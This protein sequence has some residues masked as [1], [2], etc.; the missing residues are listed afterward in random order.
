MSTKRIGYLPILFLLNLFYPY[1]I[2]G[3][4]NSHWLAKGGAPRTLS[5]PLLELKED[6]LIK[7][8]GA[9][10]QLI[11]PTRLTLDK[12]KNIY[13]LDLK[14][15]NIKVF[16]RYGQFT[17][18]IGRSG[19][20]PGELDGLN[21]IFVS[22]KEIGLGCGANRRL[23]YYSLE[24]LFLRSYILPSLITQMSADKDGNLYGVRLIG[25]KNEELS[26]QVVRFNPPKGN[27]SVIA[28]RRWKEPAPFTAVMTYALMKM[29]D[30]VV[31]NPEKGYE[32]S[33]FNQSGV[34]TNRITKNSRLTR[35]PE[36]IIKK[37]LRRGPSPFE[38]PKYYEP[39]YR[40]YADDE[41]KIFV[42]VRDK[43]NEDD[44]VQLDVFGEKG[45]YFGNIIIKQC[46][47][48]LWADKKLF[49]I[50][51][52]AEGLPVIKIYSVKW[53]IPAEK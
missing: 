22:D 15:K 14:E 23:I 1:E 37:F 20:G 25:E 30:V 47:D 33:I 21:D 19:M 7:D 28:N 44:I 52:D 17:R 36:E 5:A 24:G 48:Y 41:G 18:K 40:V 27:I 50:Q 4:D 34:L 45:D 2:P 51:E 6:L 9:N 39:Y 32:I 46:I 38:I 31:G 35:I 26:Y 49:T 13:I 12:D 43:I 3:A 29:S 42:E 8:S 11:K 53:N 16:N 10:Y